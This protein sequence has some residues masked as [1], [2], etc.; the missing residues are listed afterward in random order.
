MATR[1]LLLEIGVEELPASFIGPAVAELAAKVG[2]E[3]DNNGVAHGQSWPLGTPRRLALLVKDVAEAGQAR[4]ETV[5]GPPRRAAYDQYGQPT[6]AALGFAKA[7]GVKV[8]DLQVVAT[9]KG[10]YLAA[11]RRLAGRATPDVLADALPRI[12]AGLSFPKS[13][14]WGGGDF[15]FAR[16]IHWLV[17]L[18]G[19]EI[20]PFELANQKSGRTSFGH[21]FLA[22]GPVELAT[23]GEYPERLASAMVV[24][25]PQVRKDMVLQA[26]GTAAKTRDGFLLPDPELVELNAN[27][28]EIPSAVC[29]EFDPEFLA[30]PAEVLIT[31]MKKHQKYFAVTDRR[32]SLTNRFVAVN[33][34]LARDP[35]V[36]RRGHQRVLR[37]RLADAA[38]FVQ[39]DARRSL[40]SRIEDLKAIVYHKQLGTSYQKVERFA[41][42]AGWLAQRLAPAA[43][44]QAQ[45]A[46]W[47][48]KADLV[49]LMVGEFPELQGHVGRAY[50]LK[51][52]LDPE[53]AE[54]IRD[55]YRPTGAE[56]ELPGGPVGALVAL[57]DK[58]DTLAGLFAVGQQPSGAAD[59]F[60][61]RRAALGIIRI[62][63]DRG[64]HIN[65][66]EMIENALSPFHEQLI[67]TSGTTTQD[68]EREDAYRHRRQ[69]VI[70][71]ISEFFR[72]SM[73][74]MFAGGGFSHGFG[75]EFDTMPPNTVMGN[76]Q[77]YP[78]DV[79]DAVLEVAADDPVG[80]IA[81]FKALSEFK[82][83]P[84]FAEGAIAF[85][86]LFN[87][88][89]NQ[90]PAER[91][92]E[93]L[94]VQDEEKRLHAQAQEL[95]QAI[96][97]AAAAGRF[98]LVLAELTKLKP[99][100]DAL[101]D[102]VMVMAEEPALRANRLALVN[103]VASLFR[104]VA[105]FAR[106]QTA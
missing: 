94:F 92:E 90:S 78:K 8:A 95:A 100:V 36:V 34:T 62:L 15:R 11:E 20:I 81:R 47:L 35:E 28:V 70:K 58:M 73:Q 60:G 74:N 23:A 5:V 50:A 46:A 61:L 93:A 41:A 42:L 96:Q 64:W 22:P 77:R 37:A 52:G 91:P 83:S 106:L 48:A 40:K 54:A 39:R 9:P 31:C 19:E 68:W 63:I 18:F 3:L 12:I 1:E 27:L 7:Q 55:H 51:E 71:A 102:Q 16:P 99:A 89:K 84:S 38:Y 98:D 44:A 104:L 29:G 79:V 49:T 13:M 67:I 88:L 105:D 43:Q 30:L 45:E 59:P 69:E 21:R 6:R 86:R 2:Q 97:A 80:A 53:V 32:G 25:D 82:K 14:R 24:V 33:N 56:G 76:W 17:A 65:L 57:A 85:K 87:I 4:Q 103:S 101:F 72:G 26:A 75:P 10:E 66:T